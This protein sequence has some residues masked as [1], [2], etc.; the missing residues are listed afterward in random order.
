MV[1]VDARA[2][3]NAALALGYSGDETLLFIPLRARLLGQLLS[4]EGMQLRTL[5]ERSGGR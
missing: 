1:A 3:N 2:A 5:A 4:F